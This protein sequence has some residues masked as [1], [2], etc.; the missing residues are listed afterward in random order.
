MVRR[1]LV[2]KCLALTGDSVVHKGVELMQ[3]ACELAIHRRPESPPSRGDSG[4]KHCLGNRRLRGLSG[5]ESLLT[6]DRPR[7]TSE[8]W[9]SAS[10]RVTEGRIHRV[11]TGLDTFTGYVHLG[12]PFGQE[13]RR[14]RRMNVDITGWGGRY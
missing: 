8:I 6:P 5:H 14:V 12:R 4:G 1:A 11:G 10:P 13:R 9:T 2:Q 7:V 3:S